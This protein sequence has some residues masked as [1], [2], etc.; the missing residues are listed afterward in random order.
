MFR[1]FFKG[2]RIVVTGVA[3]VK[4]SW[5]ALELLEAG[6]QVVGVDIKSPEPMSNFMAAGLGER[7]TFVQGDVRH[8]SLM[9]QLL[10]GADGVFHLAAVALVVEARRKP[11]Q[12]YATNTLGAATVL[13][14]IRLS[15]SVKYA[16]F[17]TT[18][19]VYK[20]KAGELW[21]ETD[22]LFA[23]EPY[24]VSK[25]CAEH[26]I[27]DYY[28]TYL[29]QAGKRVGVGRAGNVIVGGDFYSSRR[30][31]GAGRIFVDCFEAL[32]EKQPPKIF[33]PHFTRPYTYGLDIL[34]GYMALMSRLDCKSVD[35]EAFNF[36]PHEQHG[37]ENGLL[38]A[39]ICEL[40]GEGIMWECG[41]ARDEPFEKQALSW[42]K[43]R[44]RLGWQPAYTLHEGLCATVRWYRACGACQ[45]L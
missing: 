14:A 2:K 37:V 24:Q 42:D 5:L 28:H 10:K 15:D 19:K 4:G 7:I 34:T 38:A 41:P 12:A 44:E 6:S 22:P 13:E 9:E 45:R 43:A 26:I 21:M 17:V 27:A 8:L 35:G 40:W 23:A 33:T 29:R 31:G 18:D 30:T 3:G 20:S 39:K 32:A 11:L 16:V 1:D 36:G 25:A